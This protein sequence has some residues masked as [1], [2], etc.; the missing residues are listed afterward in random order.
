MAREDLLNPVSEAE[1]CG[2]DLDEVGDE[3]YLNYLL[4]AEDRL[5]ER[6]YD[7]VTGEPF[8][9]AK[10]NLKAE[11]EAIASLLERSRDLRLLCLEARFQSFVGQFGGFAEALQTMAGLL[12]RF[13]P[14]VHPQPQDGDFTLR[15]N[16]LGGLDDWAKVIQPL[17]HL[18][19]L[20]DKRLGAVTFRQYAVATGAAQPREEEKGIDPGE[21]QQALASAENRE[22]ADATYAALTAAR[23]A[24]KSIRS[25]FIDGAGYEYAPD[26]D[27]LSAFLDE[28]GGLF[29]KARPEF[30]GAAAPAG[31]EEAAGADT[32]GGS[33]GTEEGTD[34][35]P[36]AFAA[37]AA[38]PAMPAGPVASHA[39][40]AAALAAAEAYFARNEPSAPAL[41]LV[42]QARLLIG[43][44][45]VEAIQ[46]LLPEAADGA[47]IRFEAELKFQLAMPHLRTLTEA[48]MGGREEAG[49]EAQGFSATT[50][51]EATGLVMAV[52]NFFRA[53]EPSSPVP[54]LLAKARTYLNR[55]FTLIL[56]DL[57]Q[58]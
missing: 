18:P 21:M 42:H 1:P 30:A 54:M 44:S 8:D 26:F 4:P 25:S 24:L 14:D 23:A 50:R 28:A 15:Q 56:N 58:K 6:Y 51:G 37:A 22:Q 52:E 47:V 38:Q 29:V 2:P 35:A 55:D 12:E 17:H 7:G 53:A 33:D 19:L 46:T 45:L 10:L 36:S 3:E 13:W 34:G 9:R 31:E 27:R 41:I 48:A 32:A 20:R 49:G 11:T 39:D 57:L 43:K 16:V 5:P 40:A